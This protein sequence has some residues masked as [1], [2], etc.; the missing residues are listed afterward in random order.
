MT[1]SLSGCSTAN[2]HW[3]F[4]FRI[5]AGLA[6]DDCLC[7]GGEPTEFRVTVYDNPKR[8]RLWIQG[9]L[10]ISGG[11]STN[12]QNRTENNP[13]LYVQK[14]LTPGQTATFPDQG[15]QVRRVSGSPYTGFVTGAGDTVQGTITAHGTAN[16]SMHVLML[17]GG[18]LPSCSGQGG[19]PSGPM[20]YY[21]VECRSLSTGSWTQLGNLGEINPCVPMIQSTVCRF[22]ASGNG[23]YRLG[24]SVLNYCGIAASNFRVTNIQ[25]N[26][27]TNFPTEGTSVWSGSQALSAGVTNINMTS[28]GA[29][30][31]LWITFTADGVNY[32]Q[33]RVPTN[34]SNCPPTAQS[35]DE[36]SVEEQSLQEQ[37][38]SSS[39]AR[40]TETTTTTEAPTTTTTTAAPTTTTSTTAAPETTETPTDG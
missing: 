32:S 36:Q 2:S 8:S 10:P 29:G 21:R 6:S 39:E 9:N 7:A 33:I 13:R 3:D 18:G 28:T 23:R 20:A 12:P 35:L 34:N 40:V 38:V 14:I 26:N 30:G 37:S 24:I 22:N 15:D 25:R 31:Q 5:T 16:D 11:S 17:P 4:N 1:V 19:A 27:D